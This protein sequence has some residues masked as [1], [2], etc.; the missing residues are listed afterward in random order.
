MKKVIISVL[1]IVVL[2]VIAAFTIPILFKDKIIAKVKSTV[3]EQLNAKVNF[4][5]FDVSI[6]SGFPNLALCLN[7]LTII[8]INEFEGDTLTSIKELKLN[9]DLMSAIKGEEIKIKSVIV[10]KALVNLLVL[11]DGK[12]NWDISKPAPT[13]TSTPSSDYR[14]ELKSYQLL[15]SEVRFNDQSAGMKLMLKDVNHSGSGDFTQ[16]LFTLSTKTNIASVFVTYGG[17][18]Y[19]NGVKTD[20]KADIEMDM[21]NSKYTFKENELALNDLA[22]GFDGF[23]AMPTDDIK[24][25]IKFAA[26]KA[27]FSSFVSLIPAIYTNDFKNLKSSGTLSFDGFVKGTYNDKSL[28]AYGL[29]LAIQNGMFQYP[30]LPTAVKNVQVDLKVNNPDGV[31]DHTIIDLK[32]L[33]VEMGSDP[34]DA[35]MFVSTPISDPNIDATVKGKINLGN[36]KN[37]VPLEKGTNLSGMLIADVTAKGRMSSVENKQY[38]NFDAHGAVSVTGMNYKS[39]TYPDGIA[40]NQFMLSFNPKNVTL[41]NCDLKM[42]NSDLKANGSF[43]NFLAYYFKNE[44]LKGSLNINSNLIDLN[45][46]MNT[47][48]STAATV[49]DTAA[50][51]VIEIPSNIDFSLNTSVTRML[52]EDLV[53]QNLKG[54]VT[55][56]NASLDMNNVTFNTLEGMVNM[57]GNYNA[58]D[59]KQPAINLNLAVTDFDIPKTAKAFITVQKMAPIAERCAGKVSSSFNVVGKLDQHMQPQLNSLTGGGTLKTGHVVLSNYEPLSKMADALKMPQYKQL[60]LDNVNLS[61]KFKN[62]RVNVEPFETNLDGTKATIEGSNGFDQTIDYN[63]NLA[64]PKAKIGTQATGVMDNLLASAN[65]S[66]GTSYSMPDPINVKVNIGGTVTHPVIKTGMKDAAM[67]VAETVK[68]EVKAVVEEKI[69]E[70]KAA[71]KVQADKLIKDAEIKAKELH[72]AAV[73]T[74][75]KAKKEGY[76]QADKLVAQAKDPIS[77]AA[78]KVAADKLKKETD[79]QSAKIIKAA[80]DEGKKLIAE[81]QKQ[82]DALLK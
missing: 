59:I 39:E 40:V 44:I 81:A 72:D 75:D 24:M 25:D 79:A 8:G 78:A 43:D 17:V 54:N 4:G 20:L 50:M 7:D 9:I 29:T 27:A 53:I 37:I 23:V 65:K 64:I 52:Y 38:E 77:K 60:A 15:H 28:P 19:L 48:S 11:K 2:V 80:D 21:K 22:I 82:A 35:R 62:G 34:F 36:I 3:N 63:V 45:Q 31:T 33:H 57:N 70:G 6:L 61:F 74:S 1:I 68:E 32:K 14:I 12:A 42:G 10:N 58:A 16:D 13:T 71:A 18:S 55:M 5:T 30:S 69:D 66:V 73:I 56:K 76:A 46:L 51:T 47:S 49:P 41:N 67:S 26:K